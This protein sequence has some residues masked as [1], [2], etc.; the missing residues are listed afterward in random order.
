MILRAA[1]TGAAGQGT[2]A[3]SGDASPPHKYLF[4]FG[5][6]E[7]LRQ[8]LGMTNRLTGCVL[9]T[10]YCGLHGW[11][12]LPHEVKKNKELLIV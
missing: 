6:S 12:Q 8:P 3:A 4:S 5:D 11:H 9:Q 7:W 1:Q 2:D 10:L